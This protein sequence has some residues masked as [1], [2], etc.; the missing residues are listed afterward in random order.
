M[1]KVVVNLTVGAEESERA[2]IAFLVGT[3]AQSAGHEVLAF[4][5][6][7][8]VRLAFPGGPQTVGVQ[9]GRPAFADLWEQFVGR[10]GVVYLCPFCVSQRALGD[11]PLSGAIVA[12]ATPMWAWIGETPATVFS[13]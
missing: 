10:G 8:A 3:A 9:E 5:T 13:Y 7:E 11:D 6:M 2:T 12:G 1:G 4:F